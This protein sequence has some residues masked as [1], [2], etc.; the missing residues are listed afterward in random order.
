[1][2]MRSDHSPAAAWRSSL[3][4]TVRRDAL[5]LWAGMFVL[6]YGYELFNFSLSIDEE[7]YSFFRRQDVPGAW[8]AQG[9]WG[10][11]LLAAILTPMSAL[12]VLSTAIFGAGLVFASA[13][14]VSHYR[15]A[16]LAPH[17]LTVVLISSPVW[18]H[19]AEFNSL[20][21]GVG[22]G[23]LLSIVG[24]RLLATRLGGKAA[25]VL[26]IAL[27]VGIYQAFVFVPVL[28]VLGQALF[29]RPPDERPM[30]IATLL[31]TLLMVGA[32]T[33]LSAVIQ[34]IVMALAGL[35][36]EY[37]GAFWRVELYFTEPLRALRTSIVAS[38]RIFLGL[39]PLYLGYGAPAVA[40]PLIG[41]ALCLRRPLGEHP[42][43]WLLRALCLAGMYVIA[44]V[45]VFVS[46]GGL[47][48]RGLV[49]VPILFSICAARLTW[50]SPAARWL[51]TVAIVG[52]LLL[53]TWT[54]ARLFYADHVVRER[55]R[56]LAY[57]ILE[58]LQPLHRP[59][60]LLQLTLVGHHQA[61][62]RE[63]AP[64]LQVFG[65]SFF[66]HDG[67]S[68]HRVQLW[69]RLL[70]ADFLTP[71]EIYE[72]PAV[73]ATAAAMPS[74]PAVGSVA[75]VDDIAVVKLGPLSPEQTHNLCHRTP[76]HHLCTVVV[77]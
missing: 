17:V 51:G 54:S 69:F 43:A 64:R 19:I 26:A 55:D 9:R 70:G 76:G 52:L 47:P 49:A 22:M 65:T 71:R 25:G 39:D 75:L 34:K 74:W 56:F 60:Q 14:L 61:T 32:A 3:T 59:G 36:L 50:S 20:A 24:V 31:G 68:A 44:A 23:L 15:L 63:P 45:P 77:P 67:G 53:G 12:P 10:M 5:L 62:D 11:A 27:A 73:A 21:H 29:S 28:V 57:R 41:V 72:L 8:L 1:M 38:G 35:S 30:R 13:H 4:L 37:I 58:R 7:I 42:R 18:P 40:L 48:V 2:S 33:L 16:G 46:V 66:E 6:V